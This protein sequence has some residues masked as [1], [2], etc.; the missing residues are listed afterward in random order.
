MFPHFFTH[1]SWLW[2]LVALWVNSVLLY[3]LIFWTH[4]R[5]NGMPLDKYDSIAIGCMAVLML[6]W[7]IP[8]A[9]V[10]PNNT[11]YDMLLPMVMILTT[12][13]ILQMALTTL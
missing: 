12:Y 11:G 5:K 4:R 8:N 2:F 9:I 7:G 6:I 3:P 10:P 13:F 1:L